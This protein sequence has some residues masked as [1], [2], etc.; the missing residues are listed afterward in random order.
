MNFF[1]VLCHL[2]KKD[3][4]MTPRQILD[5]LEILRMQKILLV[6]LLIMNHNTA[7]SRCTWMVDTWKTLCAPSPT[8]WCITLRTCVE[9]FSMLVLLASRGMLKMMNTLEKWKEKHTSK[10][11]YASEIGRTESKWMVAIYTNQRIEAILFKWSETIPRNLQVGE[12]PTEILKDLIEWP[13]SSWKI[14]M[15][16]CLT[17]LKRRI[18]S[19]L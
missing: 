2:R 3:W 1:K 14:I 7:G 12:T 9:T 6:K 10:G 15:M 5:L 13:M 16:A 17:L 4:G 8:R 19:K 11:I 18:C